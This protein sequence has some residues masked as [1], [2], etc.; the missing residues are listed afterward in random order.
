MLIS[1]KMTAAINEQVGHEF[2]ASLQ[3]VAIGSHFA[4]EGLSELAAKFYRQADEEREHAMR[5]VKYLS[6]AGGPLKIPAIPA[7]QPTFKSVEE[8]V[9]LSLDWEKTVTQQINQL[10]D[11][12]VKET[13][14]LTQTFLGWF[15]REQLEEVSSM[16]NLLKVVQRA[17][18]KNL[19]Y[20]EG[21]LARQGS[22]LIEGA[23]ASGDS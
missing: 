7:P 2:A 22:T 16:D 15:V 11:L 19:I 4:S 1:E 21:Y 10:M 12:A 20:V 5:F 18:E 8:A 23:E 6:E 13:D 17:G 14:Y 3:Y 9:R